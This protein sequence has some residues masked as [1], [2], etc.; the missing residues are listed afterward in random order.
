MPAAD[1]F[2]DEPPAAAPPEESFD[3]SEEDLMEEDVAAPGPEASAPPAPAPA[4]EPEQEEDL[5]SEVSL[6]E[7]ESPLVED[8]VLEDESLWGTPEEIAEP[9]FAEP[10]SGEDLLEEVSESEDFGFGETPV[11]SSEP[12]PAPEAPPTAADPFFTAPPGPPPAPPLEDIPEAEIVAP[13]PEPASEPVPEFIPEPEPEPVPEPVSEPV[14]EPPAMPERESAREAPIQETVPPVSLS[15]A[16]PEKAVS[17]K[18]EDAVRGILGPA[19]DEAAKK[20]VEEVAWEIIPDL[21]EAMIRSE[22][23]RIKAENS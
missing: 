1:P 23:E 10:A 15:P 7:S 12:P 17:A 22:I 8:K 5:W 3:L 13:E 19:F 21:A 16:E 6:R 4:P 11:E 9:E 14:P 20:I 18:I 2:A